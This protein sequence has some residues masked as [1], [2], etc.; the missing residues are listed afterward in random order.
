MFPRV[1][2][3]FRDGFRIGDVLEKGEPDPRGMA[4]DD[5][6]PHP[7]VSNRGPDWVGSPG[8]HVKLG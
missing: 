8:P 5:G 6:E 1:I 7:G 2:F 3:K 4:A